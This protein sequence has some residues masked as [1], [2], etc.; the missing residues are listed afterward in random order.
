MLA[1]DGWC[2]LHTVGWWF[3]VIVKGAHRPL[4]A[5]HGLE[6]HESC[7]RACKSSHGPFNPPVLPP[8]GT[9]VPPEA[10]GMESARVLEK[11]ALT[12]LQQV[13]AQQCEQPKSGR[14]LVYKPAVNPPNDIQRYQGPLVILAAHLLQAV[15]ASNVHPHTRRQ[16]RYL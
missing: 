9:M 6:A 11:A 10:T 5:H 13:L 12:T 2:Q 7:T 8:A 4:T 16:F 3:V 1:V 14:R 15:H